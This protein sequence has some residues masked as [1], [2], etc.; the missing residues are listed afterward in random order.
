EKDKHPA[1]R[2]FQAIRIFL[3]NELDELCITLKQTIDVLKI[4]GRLVV[5]SFHSLED[6]LVKRFMRNES[7]GDKFPPE[8]P[9]THEL[10]RP[11]LKIIDKPIY[12]SEKEIRENPRARSAVMRI[13]ERVRG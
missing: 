1:T 2:T 10:I 9:V 5:I 6:R 4:G 11:R 8:I 3:N 7:R 12:S 13:A